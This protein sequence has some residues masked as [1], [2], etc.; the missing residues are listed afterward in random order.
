MYLAKKYFSNVFSAHFSAPFQR[1]LYHFGERKSITKTNKN[2]IFMI[3]Q[4]YVG[5]VNVNTRQANK[6]AGA[7]HSKCPDFR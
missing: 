5:A 6:I 3:V 7:A 2:Q 1:T 4:T